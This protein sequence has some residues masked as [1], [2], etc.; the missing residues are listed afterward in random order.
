MWVFHTRFTLPGRNIPVQE[1]PEEAYFP[2]GP[3]NSWGMLRTVAHRCV[4]ALSARFGE[5]RPVY[6]GVWARDI[7]GITVNNGELS[8]EK[9]HPAPCPCPFSQTLQK[10]QHS[11]RGTGITTFEQESHLPTGFTGVYTPFCSDIHRY[12]HRNGR[13]EQ[14]QQSST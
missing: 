7:Q 2:Y 8:Q 10:Q 14:K 11:H 3:E 9:T 5:V 6:S 12:S 1:C 4:S 13:K